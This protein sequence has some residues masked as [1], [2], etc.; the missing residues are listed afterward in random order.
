VEAYDPAQ[1]AFMRLGPMATPRHG[2]NAA[3]LGSRVYLPGG[4][5]VEGFGVTGVNEAF[6][7]P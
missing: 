1:N 3:V 2:I 6:D 7:A 5:T 4:A